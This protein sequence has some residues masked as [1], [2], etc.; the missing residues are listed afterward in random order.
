MRALQWNRANGNWAVSSNNRS[1]LRA[2]MTPI[3]NLPPYP[4]LA[5]HLFKDDR[6]IAID[7]AGVFGPLWPVSLAGIG[8]FRFEDM[9]A[10]LLLTHKPDLVLMPLFADDFDC[11][12]AIERLELFGFTGRMLVLAP[13]LPKPRQVEAELRGLGCGERLVLITP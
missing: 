7:C 11:I 4:T 13:N 10:A 5:D 8:Q 6:M 9:T 1:S 3:P 12:S 2:L